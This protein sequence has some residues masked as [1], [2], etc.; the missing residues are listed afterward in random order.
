MTKK[1]LYEIVT[2][3]DHRPDQA[4]FILI[5]AETPDHPHALFCGLQLV[6]AVALRADLDKALAAYSLE[7]SARLYKEKQEP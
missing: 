7:R 2:N 5:I 3:L 6:E 4:A 1:T